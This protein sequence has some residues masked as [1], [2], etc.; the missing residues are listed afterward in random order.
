MNLPRVKLDKTLP[1]SGDGGGPVESPRYPEIAL[2]QGGL[3]SDL[4]N[5]VALVLKHKYMIM[6]I[7]TIFLLGGVI[8]TL[9]MPKIYSAS[10]TVK[11]DRLVPQIF[12]SQYA[13]MSV[14][15]DD[16]QFYETQ[17]ELIRSR[18]IAERVTT[19]LDLTKSDFLGG[20]QQSWLQ[21]LFGRKSNPA[22]VPDVD[23]GKCDTQLP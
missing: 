10:T 19:A 9:Q 18:A 16:T 20:P 23:A 11:I 1:A 7:V 17:Y 3:Q 13:Q 22:P 6:I 8:V 14:W 4:A 15:S 2:E 21:R 12:K 5:Y